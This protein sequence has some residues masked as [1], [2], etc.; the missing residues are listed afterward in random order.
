MRKFILLLF[1]YG[2]I[3]IYKFSFV[4]V[5][6][7]LIPERGREVLLKKRKKERPKKRKR[8]HEPKVNVG[9]IPKQ[10]N[11][12]IVFVY[13][14]FH[15]RCRPFLSLCILSC[16]AV[17][18][19]GLLKIERIMM[20]LFFCYKCR[21]LSDNIVG[22]ICLHFFP[23]VLSFPVAS[24]HSLF[25]TSCGHKEII[26]WVIISAKHVCSITLLSSDNNN[27]HH[28]SSISV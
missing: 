20:I 28:I 2:E 15:R 27:N 18:V 5:F 21:C 6:M 22:Q 8:Q 3:S 7:L 1:F 25:M 4:V 12:S 26:Y 9:E 24:L 19:F 13:F 23:S 16:W 17:S 11:H 10:D 14:F